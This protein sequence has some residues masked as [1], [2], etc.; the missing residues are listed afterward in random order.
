MLIARQEM[1][2]YLNYFGIIIFFTIITKQ[3]VSRD[4]I[5]GEFALREIRQNFLSYLSMDV[6]F[7]SIALGLLHTQKKLNF[8]HII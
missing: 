4:S 2:M 8:V 3:G 5:V 6:I 1:T 7:C